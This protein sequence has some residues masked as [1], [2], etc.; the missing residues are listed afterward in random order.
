EIMVA[1]KNLY[2]EVLPRLCRPSDQETAFDELA[3]LRMH[4]LHLADLIGDFEEAFMEAMANERGEDEG[5]GREDYPE[6]EL[7]GDDILDRLLSAA[8][9]TSPPLPSDQDPELN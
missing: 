6:E 3:G 4:L 2:T 8:P 1:S 7:E 5:P 9:P